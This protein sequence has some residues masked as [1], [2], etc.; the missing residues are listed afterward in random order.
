MLALRRARELG[1]DEVELVL[2]SKLVV[3]QLSGRWKV[4]HPVIA[5]LANQAQAELRG[6]RGWK[7]RHEPRAANTAADALANLALDDPGA[8]AA[9]EAGLGD[10]AADAGPLSWSEFAAEA[11]DLAAAGE[12][13]I[14]AFSVGYLATLDPAG[15]PRVH[16]VSLSLT[17][18]GLY[19]FVI[20]GT[21]RARDLRR[22]PRYALHTFPHAP[23]ADEWDDEHFEMEG[24]AVEVTDGA[25]RARL[26]AAHTDTV[27]SDDLGYEL[28]IERA[29]WKSPQAGRVV[30]RRW[31]PA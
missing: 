1:A 28:R 30:V 17:D 21:R 23:T 4:R 5:R 31:P 27:G 26:A 18:G 13:L 16:P 11:P 2:D 6:F 10:P 7:V 20:A 14:R 12:R 25:E 19:V 22:D 29:H 3:E 15:G 8:A 9:A 24:R